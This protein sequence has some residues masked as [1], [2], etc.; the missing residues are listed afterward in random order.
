MIWYNAI[1]GAG[2]DTL[3][4]GL[5][6]DLLDGGA[7]E[8]WA[9]FN[10]IVVSGATIVLGTDGNSANGSTGTSNITGY[11]TTLVGI[12]HIKATALADIITGD[13]N[14]NSILA[15]GSND[16]IYSSKGRVS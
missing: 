2:N 10:D 1:G 6:A 4:G 5:G 3:K 7:N 9:Y 15:G 12:E 13:H 16:T 11:T 14:A 8:D